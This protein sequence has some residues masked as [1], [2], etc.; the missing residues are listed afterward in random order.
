MP[1]HHTSK[2]LRRKFYNPLLLIMA[3]WYLKALVMETTVSI[4]KTK[5]KTITNAWTKTQTKKKTKT[6]PLNALKYLIP[7]IVDISCICNGVKCKHTRSQS[8]SIFCD[9]SSWKETWIWAIDLVPVQPW[10]AL[11]MPDQILLEPPWE[12]TFAEQ[13]HGIQFWCLWLDK[14]IDN[15]LR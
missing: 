6:F 4:E 9:Q 8:I 5:T 13:D 10:Q 14:G 1:S 7:L 11:P 15:L 2:I 3:L 12:I